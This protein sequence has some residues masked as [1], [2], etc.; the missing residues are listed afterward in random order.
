MTLKATVQARTKATQ[1]IGYRIC[2]IQIILLQHYP[3]KLPL[4]S[5]RRRFLKWKKKAST[6]FFPVSRSCGTSSK[7][8]ENSYRRRSR[9]SGNRK[10][11]VSSEEGAKKTFTGK[12]VPATRAGKAIFEKQGSEPEAPF[13]KS[14]N[15]ES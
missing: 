11:K 7:R 13:S 2:P 5:Q 15:R 6:N 8:V 10:A 3:Q 12:D 1:D 14:T 9:S 4:I